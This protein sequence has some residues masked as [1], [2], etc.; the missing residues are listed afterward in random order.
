MRT[1]D[2]RYCFSCHRQTRMLTSAQAADVLNVSRR[3][4]YRWVQEGKIHA[5][6]IPS[7]H[8][9]ICED[10]LLGSYQGSYAAPPSRPVDERIQ[11]VLDMIEEQYPHAHLTLDEL[12]EQAGM[13]AGYLSKLFKRET[14]SRFRQYLRALRL[15]KAET[16]LHNPLLSIKEV[17]I[18]VGYPPRCVSEFTRHFKAAYGMTPSEYR[19]SMALKRD[20]AR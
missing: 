17:A 14:G 16:L 19:Q 3:T 10:S 15:R 11:L 2:Y 4:I 13:S 1:S 6:R 7:G 18:R 20:R 12:S 9:R 5:T 8:L